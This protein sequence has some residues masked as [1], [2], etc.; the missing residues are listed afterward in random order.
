MFRI[1]SKI[2]FIL[3]G[4]TCFLTIQAVNSQDTGEFPFDP[5][6]ILK[7]WDYDSLVKAMGEG[8]HI[9]G[10]MKK[11]AYLAGLKYPSDLLRMTGKLEF[12]FNKDSI[13]RF[14]FRK[15]HPVRVISSDQADRMARDTALTADYNRGIMALDSLRRDSVVKAI[16]GILGQPIS[17]GRTPATEK[18]ARHS[19]IWINN[20]YTCQYKDYLSYSEIGFSISTI[21]Q[22][23][24]GEF[25]LPAATE[26]LRKTSVKTR[27]MSWSASLLGFPSVASRSVYSDLFLMVEYSTGQRYVVSIPYNPIS[28]LPAFSFEDCDGDAIPEAWIQVPANISG[29]LTR[30]YLFSLSFKE[31]NLIF[32]SDDQIPISL[33]YQG[34]SGIR[35]TFPDGTSQIVTGKVKGGGADQNTP[36]KPEAFRYLRTTR[37]NNDG[38]TNFTG[39]IDLM[40]SPGTAGE[41]LL[42]ITYRHIPG[43]WEPGSIQLLP[44]KQ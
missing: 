35:V 2:R 16:T 10:I 40:H 36:F 17:S 14:Q 43:G 38:S 31:P 12:Q 27:R 25:D 42:E 13:A 32:S 3:T 23:A 44:V 18:S 34:N 26:I 24:V 4:L 33:T 8:E 11:Q 7:T 5:Y 29:T 9:M 19:A 37:L 15:E 1:K 22:W 20:G 41:G 39:G 6:A 28:Y 30:H 21:P